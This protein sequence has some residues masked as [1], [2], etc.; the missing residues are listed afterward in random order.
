MR[1]LSSVSTGLVLF[2][3]PL[4]APLLIAPMAF[5]RMAHPDGEVATARAAAA[6]GIPIVISTMSTVTLED[7]AAESGPSQRWFQ[8]YLH[9]DRGLSRRLL[10]RA[11]ASGCSAVVL[12]VDL[13]VVGRRRRDEANRFHLPEGLAVANLEASLERGGGSA[14]SE[15]SDAA[16]EPSLTPDLLEWIAGVTHLPLLVKGVLHPDDAVMAADAG[17][18]G[19]IVS[20]HGGRQLDGAIASAD[21]L[22]AIAD[23]LAGRVPVLVDG[24]I[25]S[26][27]DIVKALAMGATAVLIG[28]PVLWALAVGGEQ[29]VA[30]L[31]EELT[32]EFTRAM[33]LCGAKAVGEIERSLIA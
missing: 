10:E 21:A 5:Q 14:L 26:G 24:G 18:A 6:A 9:R 17:A 12:T 27:T 11:E 16:F 15:Y 13:P 29:G 25:R 1:D 31:L 19:V 30:S 32:E 3:N 22:P 8:F 4:A 2:G 28:R 7:I 33:M 20:N 23:R